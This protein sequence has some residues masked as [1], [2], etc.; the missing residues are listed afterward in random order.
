MSAATP[1]IRAASR[2]RLLVIFSPFVRGRRLRAGCLN[3]VTRFAPLLAANTRGRARGTGN[4]R[5]LGDALE[6]KRRTPRE[7]LHRLDRA[8]FAQVE[9]GLVVRGE[10]RAQDVW[11]A[12]P[13]GSAQPLR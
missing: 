2:T 5:Y 1:P 8:C 3:S 6:R 13:L 12:G 10:D 7:F 11:W 9:S 4:R